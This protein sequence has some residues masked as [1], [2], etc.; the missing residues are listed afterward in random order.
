[1]ANLAAYYNERGE[2]GTLLQTWQIRPFYGGFESIEIF[3][4]AR[5]LEYHVDNTL[6]YPNF[7]EV[8][9]LYQNIE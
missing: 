2:Y 7:Q 9:Q 5:A 4:N 6:S 3:T 8:Y 1:M